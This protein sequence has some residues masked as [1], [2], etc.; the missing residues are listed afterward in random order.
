MND[1]EL[2]F[3]QW[4]APFQELIIEFT[5]QRLPEKLQKAEALVQGRLQQLDQGSNHRNEKIALQD[6]LSI[7]RVMKSDGLHSVDRNK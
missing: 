3:P 1:S 7:L 5:L 6:A 4:Q 2:K